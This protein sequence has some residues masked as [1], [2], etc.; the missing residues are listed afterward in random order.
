MLNVTLFA[1]GSPCL[2]GLRVETASVNPP[3][4]QVLGTPPTHFVKKLDGQV[5]DNPRENRC[6]FHHHLHPSPG[7]FKSQDPIQTG[8]PAHRLALPID[9]SAALH[10][11]T[12][13]GGPYFLAIGRWSASKEHGRR[14]QID[15]LTSIDT[16][17]ERPVA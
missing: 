5:L 16:K 6:Y 11:T 8:L 2:S 14:L 9:P 12:L 4:I 7:S 15:K 17:L 3:N 10:V 13:G 1:A